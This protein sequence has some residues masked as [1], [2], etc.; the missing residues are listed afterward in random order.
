MDRGAWRAIVNRVA[1]SR[2]RLTVSAQTQHTPTYTL[3][4]YF[5]K[6]EHGTICPSVKAGADGGCGSQLC[7]EAPDGRDLGLAFPLLPSP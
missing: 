7:F 4:R 5:G 2:T 3:F 6:T 1:K